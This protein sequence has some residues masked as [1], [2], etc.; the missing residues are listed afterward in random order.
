MTHNTLLSRLT[1][2]QH[3][4]LHWPT[5]KNELCNTYRKHDPHIILINSHGLN[6]DNPLKIY[7]YTT[8]SSNKSQERNDGVAIAIKNSIQ[9]KINNFHSDLLAVEI[10]TQGPIILATL[11]LPPRRPCIPEPDILQLLRHNKPIYIMGDF[12]AHH[13]LFG[14]NDTNNV[15]RGFA[16]Y[17][18]QG[19][20]THLG[21]H[22]PTY[23]A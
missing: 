9:H 20:L 16:S 5:R 7:T 13:P 2:I 12:N 11:Y 22:T 21:P 3:N 14:Y 23:I 8:Y 15:G 17:M 4:V 19:R 10:N 6:N 18:Q 1:I